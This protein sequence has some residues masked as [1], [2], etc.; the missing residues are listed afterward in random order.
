MRPV[1]AT[2]LLSIALAAGACEEPGA[3]VVRSLTFVGAEEGS[4]SQLK[5][6]LATRQSS[7]LPWGRKEYFDRQRF[8]AD[9][10]RIVAF[11]ADRG[12]T[13]AQVTGFDVDQNAEQNA[14]DL[15]ITIA[16]GEPLLV[17]GIDFIGFTDVPPER[18]E[19]LKERAP[20]EVGGP[21][22]RRL[23][24]AT[25]D[26]ALNVLRDEGFPY[27]RVTI[28]EGAGRSAKEVMLRFTAESGPLAHF[29]PVEIVGNESVSNRIIDRA[30]T[31]RP[32]DLYRRRAVLES[33]RRLYGME[34]FQFVNVET[35]D[36]PQQSPEVRTRVTIAEGNHQRVNFGVGYGTE[37]KARVDAEYHHV[38]FLG[39]ARSAGVHGRWS[40]LD[41]GVRFD[42]I[43]P[44]LFSPRV[45]FGAEGQHWFTTTPAYESDRHGR[46]DDGDTAA[47][48]GHVPGGIDP[49]RVYEQLHYRS[50]PQ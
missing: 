6:A 40:S 27:A 38:N 9:L 21:R 11:Y 4:E 33:Q 5:A 29:G 45:T 14:V 30:L 34:L 39:G 16:L 20:L 8:E 48:S 50:R 35:V 19:E 15:T 1:P 2:V 49:E 31:F 44:Y 13:D 47:P 7:R 24:L 37:E 22:D 17:S 3:T 26:L 36:S 12:Y 42:F 18:Y 32:G 43:Q 23:V 25:H 10:K 28:D 41:R 46:Q